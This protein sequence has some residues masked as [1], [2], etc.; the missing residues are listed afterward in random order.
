[1]DAQ[2]QESTP[3]EIE[4]RKKVDKLEEGLEKVEEATIPL[5]QIQEMR[6]R[7]IQQMEQCSKAITNLEKQL[8]MHKL[9]LE[10]IK[11]AIFAVDQLQGQ[12]RKGEQNA[13]KTGQ[14]QEKSV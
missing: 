8:E 1:M 12:Q 5:A 9:Q 7:F 2:K 10:Q 3:E 11:G 13:R 6:T 4:L 14:A